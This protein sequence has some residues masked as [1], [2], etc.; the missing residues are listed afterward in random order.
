MK[1]KSRNF[2][3]YTR[4]IVRTLYITVSAINTRACVYALNSFRSD[5][6]S[7]SSSS[8]SAEELYFDRSYEFVSSEN[9]FTFI[10]LDHRHVVCYISST[11]LLL[12]YYYNLYLFAFPFSFAVAHFD[13]LFL[14]VFLFCFVCVCDIIVNNQQPKHDFFECE[15]SVSL[16]IHFLSHSVQLIPICSTLVFRLNLRYYCVSRMTKKKNKIK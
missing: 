12:L 16:S 4:S 7:S 14:F 10:F 11:D 9:V 13:V 1:S 2:L 3:L 5:N 15:I 6:M 8:I